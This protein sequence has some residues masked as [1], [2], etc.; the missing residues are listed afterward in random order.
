MDDLVEILSSMGIGCHLREIFV[1]ILLYAD[2]MALLA[3]SLNGLQKLL[4]ATEQ[5]CKTWDI[6][7]NAKKSKNLY[8][9][10]KHNPAKLHLDSKEIEWVAT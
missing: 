1:S 5:Y 3:P 2:D 6:M 8:F 9:G 10:K 7:L 4:S